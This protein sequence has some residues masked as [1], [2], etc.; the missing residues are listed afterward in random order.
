MTSSVAT[1]TAELGALGPEILLSL[2]LCVVLVV[3]LFLSQQVA[4][5]LGPDSLQ[6]AG[7]RV[8][9]AVAGDEYDRMFLADGRHAGTIAQALIARLFVATVNGRLGASLR[10]LSDREIVEYASRVPAPAGDLAGGA[11]SRT[12]FLGTGDAP[13]R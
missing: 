13:G 12:A 4:R 9:R 6:L 11:A 8:S 3:D 1:L 5:L 7:C 10:P 2:G